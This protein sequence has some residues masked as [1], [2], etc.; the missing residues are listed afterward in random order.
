M[1][2][3]TPSFDQGHQNAI[4]ILEAVKDGRGRMIKTLLCTCRKKSLLARFC[5]C[6]DDDGVNR[7]WVVRSSFRLKGRKMSSTGVFLPV[8]PSEYEPTAVI[9][10]LPTICPECRK[11]WLIYPNV[12]FVAEKARAGLPKQG[13]QVFL[14]FGPSEREPWREGQNYEAFTSTGNWKRGPLETA[15]LELSPPTQ[16]QVSENPT[17]GRVTGIER[18]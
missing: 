7:T 9:T 12:V 6:P 2:E 11:G 5:S 10:P 3:N 13:D 1:T 8:D 15:I 18:L 14:R 4:E 17:P 16:G